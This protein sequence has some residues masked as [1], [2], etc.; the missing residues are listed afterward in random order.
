MNMNSAYSPHCDAFR[1][2]G[3]DGPL[4]REFLKWA[5]ALAVFA[6][7]ANAQVSNNASLS[8][9]YFFRQVALLTSGTVVTQT[10]SA[11][12]TLTFDGFGNL[13]VAGLQM[14]GTAPSTVLSGAGTYTVNPGGFVTFTNPLLP[15]VT[16]NARIGAESVLVGSSTEAGPNTFDLLIATRG[17]ANAVSNRTLSGPY[18]IS[19]L[20]FPNGGTANVRDTNFILTASGQGGFAETSVTGQ[21]NNLGNTLMTQNVGPISYLVSADGSGTLTFPSGSNTSQLI[22]GVEAIYVSQD[23]SFFI[24]G[25]T[26]AGGHGLI[27]GM[28]AWAGG[29]TNSA[30]NA[31]WSG[32][33]FAAG[34]RYDTS[35]AT[36]S[37]VTASV[38]PT[39]YGAVWERRTRQT[40]GLFD[41]TPLLTYSLTADG[42]GTYT[43]TQGHVD[44]ASTA[45]TFSTSGVDVASSTSYELYFG[46][47][48]LAQSG[49]NV[50]LHPLGI[51]NAASYAPPG[52]PVSPGG[53]VALF[54]NG[55]SQV[56]DQS[57]IPFQISLDNVQ[58]TVNGLYAP[59][60][61]VSPTQV[62]AV[63]PYGITGSTATFVVI[64]DTNSSN[65]VTVP[66][67]PTSA[68]V[69]SMSSNGLGDGAI[70]HNADASIVN[71]ASPA[72]PAEFVQVYLTGLGSVNPAVADGAAAPTKTF[73]NVTLPAAVY[74]G[75][76]KISN[77]QFQG[78]S[79]GM[80]SLY[81]LNIQIPTN[82]APGPQ[83]LEVQTA[84]GFTSLVDIWIGR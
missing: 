6:A 28:R 37:A 69:F 44:L 66:L 17:P 55:L 78:L 2:A 3:A 33:Y 61:A 49:P 36:L 57:G 10:E 81:Q 22:Q 8:G 79:P 47:S 1:R 59:V 7:A 75:G 42:S 64:N 15:G 12:G 67:A 50:F 54:G 34:M 80:A 40:N 18:W 19:S 73:A 31:N 9:K 71:Q 21:A 29:P 23:G 27:V 5:V 62:N 70:R 46:A 11:W 60:Y 72:V 51:F 20:E 65:S 30:G 76:V 82:L 83:M 48:A 84:N 45:L 14:S 63:V 53:F 52:L 41:N 24:G 74:I 68:G 26:A 38:N 56:K 32:F 43:S 35:S 39:S 58:V 13:T 77:I 25:S 16:V 4:F